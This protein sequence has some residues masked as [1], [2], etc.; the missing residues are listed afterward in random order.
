MHGHH[1]LGWEWL[2]AIAQQDAATLSAAHRELVA[3][4]AYPEHTKACEYIRA[5][6]AKRYADAR[7]YMRRAASSDY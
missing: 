5:E 4:N 6:A 1:I 2:A 3:L 7:Y